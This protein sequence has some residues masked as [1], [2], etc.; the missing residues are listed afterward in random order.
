MI[1]TGLVAGYVIAWTVRKARRVAGRLDDEADAV[2]DGGLDRLHEMV[3]ARLDN[4]PVLAELVQEAQQAALNDG[5]VSAATRQQVEKALDAAAREDQ[6]FGQAVTK[7]AAW[8]RETQQSAEQKTPRRETAIFAGDVR[9]K[10]DRGGIAF[11]QVVGDVYL[12]R[13][14]ENPLQPGRLGH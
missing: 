3:A 7:L 14:T 11:G 1:E 8:L 12:A 6:S 13:E 10:A 2:I 4:H 5:E 9:A